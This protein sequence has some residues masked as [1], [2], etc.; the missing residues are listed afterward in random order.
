MDKEFWFCTPHLL[1]QEGCKM[2][3]TTGVQGE[4]NRNYI[5]SQDMFVTIL[6]DWQSFML[7]IFSVYAYI[8]GCAWNMF[9]GGV[10]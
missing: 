2:Y 9:T 10:G 7:I 5:L 4:N 1:F 3:K 8:G 6:E